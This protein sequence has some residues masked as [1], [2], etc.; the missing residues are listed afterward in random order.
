[1][2]RGDFD[3][4][5]WELPDLT[6]DWLWHDLDM[7]AIVPP[8]AGLV[9]CHLNI[10]STDAGN[11]LRFRKKGQV[12]QS[13]MSERITQVGNRSASYG[14][15]IMPNDDAVAEY[16]GAVVPWQVIDIIVRGWFI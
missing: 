13:N 3:F 12:F 15:W 6:L 11:L 7:S 16:L 14:I 8:G 10:N 5:D 9:L 2:D 1:M 4:Y